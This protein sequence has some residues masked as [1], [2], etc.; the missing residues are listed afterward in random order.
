MDAAGL[1]LSALVLAGLVL[2]VIDGAV[3]YLR[4]LAH[5]RSA[6]DRNTRERILKFMIIAAGRLRCS[7]LL[8]RWMCGRRGLFDANPDGYVEYEVEYE[9]ECSDEASARL[10]NI[11]VWAYEHGLYT[12]DC[13]GR[14]IKEFGLSNFPRH[15]LRF[16][17]SRRASLATCAGGAASVTVDAECKRCCG[18]RLALRKMVLC[19]IVLPNG[20]ADVVRVLT[21][22][23][24]AHPDGILASSGVDTFPRRS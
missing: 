19:N 24:H 18:G 16:H 5:P 8:A 17:L 23:L 21:N 3:T 12:A 11:V 13:W 14:V 15:V 10:T 22:G 2:L 4:R 7:R 6:R 9:D 20:D 1:A